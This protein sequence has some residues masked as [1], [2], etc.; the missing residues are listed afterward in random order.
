M[1]ARLKR[2][3]RKPGCPGTTTDRSGYCEKHQK[4]DGT[5][6]QWQKKKGNTTQR[7]YGADWRKIRKRILERDSYL[8]QSCMR[9]GILTAANIVDHIKARAH[10]GDN[11][12]SN[13]EA[14]CPQCHTQKTATERSRQGRG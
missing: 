5:W 11:S 13:L 2:A 1:P 3:C 4:T 7:G 14:I 6:Q 8:C 10:G 12:D 9:K